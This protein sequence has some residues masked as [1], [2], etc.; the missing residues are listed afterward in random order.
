M[1]QKYHPFSETARGITM[2]C[3]LKPE[4][5]PL[6][7]MR[8][9]NKIYVRPRTDDLVTRSIIRNICDQNG[10]VY[11]DR[12][13]IQRRADAKRAGRPDQ[14]MLTAG[15]RRLEW[16]KNSDLPGKTVQEKINNL[17]DREKQACDSLKE[18]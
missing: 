13:T 11:N 16:L 9:A 17:I 15:E 8:V 12:K 6:E 14:I 10:Y 4:E 1:P 3:G 18:K 7:V 2:Q 5:S